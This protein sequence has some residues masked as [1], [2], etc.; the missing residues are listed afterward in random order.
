MHITHSARHG[1]LGC[2]ALMVFAAVLVTPCR[3]QDV[4]SPK[5]VVFGGAGTMLQQSR[6]LGEMHL[7]ASFEESVP[8][9]W[10]GLAFEGGYV[11]PWSRLKAGSGILSFNYMPS[12]QADKQ[13]RFLPF[14]TLGYTHLFGTGNA[15]NYGGGLDL[16][17]NNIHAIRFEARDYYSPTHPQTAQHNVAFRVGWVI[18]LWD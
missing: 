8:N 5:L 6:A 3:A 4:V 17:L 1:F 15:V 2:L 9:H 11:G 14:A 12:W 7:G 18:Y 16:R 10:Y 13:G